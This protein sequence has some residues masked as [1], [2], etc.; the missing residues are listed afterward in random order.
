MELPSPDDLL[1]RANELPALAVLP[2]LIDGLNQP[3]YLVGGAVRDLLRDMPVADIDISV[4]GSIQPLV[5]RLSRDAEAADAQ[6]ADAEAGDAET[7]DAEA[8]V[9]RDQGVNRDQQT[10]FGTATVIRRGV[11]YDLAQARTETYARPGAL[12]DV[13][14]ADIGGDLQRRDFS[15]NA[16][17]LALNPRDQ[18]ARLVSAENAFEDL[19]AQRLRVLHERS[20]LD[21]PTR[22]LRLA[23]YAA[24]LG[25][26]IEQTTRELAAE[27]LRSGALG[28]VSGARIGNEL[29]ML[30]TELDPLSALT[31][32]TELGIAA[33]IDPRFSLDHQRQE[34][35]ADAL[36]L[37]P[38]DGRPDLVALAVAFLDT[39]T[40]A[41]E[42]LLDEFS[43]TAADRDTVVSAAGARRLTHALIRARSP[44]E[45]YRT[46][47]T[48]A[49][50]A[51]AV[52]GALGAQDAASSWL[53]EL[54]HMRLQITGDDLIA[55]GIPEGPAIGAA[56][57]AARAAMLDG[58]ADD[59]VSQLRVALEAAPNA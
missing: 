57:A 14:P 41:L 26:T 55:D 10:R 59:R 20:F 19:R 58:E 18:G 9:D 39:P 38:A 3:I 49:I 2:E 32:L 42:R 35:A 17:A 45:I 6:V 34:V 31:K 12:P 11:R 27:A 13:H 15:V 21:D 7:A 29:R 22:L 1:A 53:Q 24:R 37:L 8:G 50:E 5:R 51:V 56:L 16:I 23:R 28:T 30:A 43:F 47:K 54:R 46:V 25:F 40:A 4:E 48:T 52:A 33:A 44:S 36:Q